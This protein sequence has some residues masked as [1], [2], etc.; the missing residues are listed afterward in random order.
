[1]AIEFDEEMEILQTELCKL[2]KDKLTLEKEIVGKQAMLDYLTKVTQ[3][4]KMT[5]FVGSEGF[6][7]NGKKH[8]TL[9]D[10]VEKIIHTTDEK[11]FSSQ[12]IY[13]NLFKTYPLFL[14]ENLKSRISNILCKFAKEGK[15]EI[16][17]R[18]SGRTPSRY[19]SI[20][21]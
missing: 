14:N 17:F 3:H 9:V 7:K 1:M 6:Y 21:L 20:I 4:N 15:I 16:V 19:K 18:G 13:D 8:G 11:E 5:N 12:S 10:Y 2:K